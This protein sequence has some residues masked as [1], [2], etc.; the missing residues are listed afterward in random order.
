VSCA[1][2]HATG[3]AD[4]AGHF[5]AKFVPFKDV[6]SGTLSGEEYTLDQVGVLSVL[7]CAGCCAGG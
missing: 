7:R 1:S 4:N 2:L 5:N 3:A 6:E